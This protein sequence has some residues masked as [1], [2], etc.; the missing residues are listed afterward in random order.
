MR[1]T[2]VSSCDHISLS[3][4]VSFICPFPVSAM[5]SAYCGITHLIVHKAKLLH[6]KFQLN[7]QNTLQ[8]SFSEPCNAPI[9]IFW[10]EGLDLSHRQTLR[11][12]V[13]LFNK[14]ILKARL[15]LEIVSDHPCILDS[16]N[17]NPNFEISKLS[18]PKA[19]TSVSTGL[20]CLRKSL[21]KMIP[22]FKSSK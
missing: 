1:A 10:F 2:V 12:N 9:D 18:I 3:F 11:S 6:Q 7:L 22:Q 20:E 13:P 15:I 16:S 5:F 19:L 8:R 21:P 4:S 17:E 14:S